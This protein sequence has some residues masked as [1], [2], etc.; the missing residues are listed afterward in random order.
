M[1]EYHTGA[2][3]SDLEDKL[4]YEGFLSPAVLHRFAEYMHKNRKQEDGNLRAADNWQK[5]MSRVDYMD[6]MLRH[7][8]EVWLNHRMYWN[9]A[10]DDIEEALCGVMFNAMGYLFEEMENKNGE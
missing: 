4:Q 1:R 5:G 3:R 10:S 8:M 6:S 7:V 9:L 2:T